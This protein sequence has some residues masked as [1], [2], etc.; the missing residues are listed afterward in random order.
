MTQ[1]F[2]DD[3]AFQD[4][5]AAYEREEPEDDDEG[6]EEDEQEDQLRRARQRGFEKD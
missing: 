5:Q 4:A 2:R 6:E 1:D 3:R